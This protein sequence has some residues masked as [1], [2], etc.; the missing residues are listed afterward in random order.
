MSP[1]H[2]LE[3]RDPEGSD[4]VEVDG[5][6]VPDVVDLVLEAATMEAVFAAQ[7]LVRIDGMRRELLTEARDRGA[8][9][10]D[11]VERSIRLE[12]A[13]AMRV[14][15]YAAA[16]MIVVAEALVHRYPAALDSL[17]G[18]RMTPKHAERHRSRTVR[19]CARAITS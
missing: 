2:P 16:R 13:A 5:I 17:S 15:E 11:I 8:G 6:P 12:L 1:E 14:T 7:R 3:P 10:T 19:R 18:G 9:V 4:E